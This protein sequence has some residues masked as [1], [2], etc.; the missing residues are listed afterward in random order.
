MKKLAV[1]LLVFGGAFALP[2][3]DVGA[4][5]Y[6][7]VDANGIITY[8]DRKPRNGRY[9]V[10]HFKC[11][12]CGWK[13]GVDW[14]QVRLNIDDYTAEILAA[15]RRHGVDEALVRAIIHAES[16]FRATAVSDMGAQGLMQLMPATQQRF[17]VSQ[18]F[19]PRQNI[20][21]GVR[22]LAELLSAFNNNDRLASAAYNAGPTAVRKHGGVPPYRETR[23]FVD[24]VRIL[25]NRY[26]EVL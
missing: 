12:S 15:C 8:S 2:G 1:G 13:R 6:K 20:D 16:S 4:E 19:N 26:S 5:I 17:G 21:A 24:R 25:R 23:D 22:Y 18:P 7:S 11:S 3:S 10:L 14:S 9:T